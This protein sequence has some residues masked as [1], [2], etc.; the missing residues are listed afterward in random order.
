[1]SQDPGA[2]QIFDP[3]VLA[4][5]YPLYAQLRQAAPVFWFAP[6]QI[7]LLTRYE[8]VVSLF[9][10][11]QTFSSDRLQQILESQVGDAQRDA[12]EAFVKV[13]S[14][15]L[16]LLDPPDHTR[17]RNLVVRAFNPQVA[18]AMRP[19]IQQIVDAHLD[20]AQSA[21]RMDVVRDYA[22]PVAVNVVASMIGVPA[23]DRA[24]FLPWSDDL[25]LFVGVAPPAADAA[26]RAKRS[27]EE[28]VDY[29]RDLMARRRKSPERDLISE[30][31]RSEEQGQLLSEE[32]LYATCILL[33]SAGHETTQNLIAS[34]IY[35]LLAHP[36]QL[37]LLKAD[38]TLVKGAVEELLR[39][40]PPVQCFGRIARE[41]VALH[42]HRV[43][44]GQ[45]V[46]ASFA[47]ANRDPSRFPNPDQFDI[48]RDTSGH[49]AFG[50]GI[51]FCP[52]SSLGRTEAQI[53]IRSIFQRFPSMRL[54]S[55][56]PQWQANSLLVRGLKSLDVTF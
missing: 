48:K 40:E 42:G 55:E 27:L 1:M 52:G 44:K 18:E 10:D 45:H 26:Q 4:N 7:W 32:E 23:E 13:A 28:M 36:D 15:W 33:L 49:L 24:K 47:A 14:R 51:H 41:D 9:K 50:Y 37:D 8:D 30:L 17:V 53:A 43:A 29:F 19:R 12:F 35:L 56:A 38:W 5:P 46:M 3:A 6:A 34:A 25:G 54:V 21:G 39:F 16:F 31:I 11:T 22:Q 2:A 20:A